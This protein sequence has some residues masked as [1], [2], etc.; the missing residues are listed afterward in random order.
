MFQRG[1][2]QEKDEWNEQDGCK[3]T[4][5]GCLVLRRVLIYEGSWD[6]P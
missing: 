1:M 6:I 2:N 5:G 4:Y 3:V